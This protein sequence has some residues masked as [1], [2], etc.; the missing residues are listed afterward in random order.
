MLSTKVLKIVILRILLL[1]AIIFTTAIVGVAKTAVPAG[2]VP[3]YELTIRLL[4]E[5]H[6]IEVNGT[7]QLPVTNV[8][9]EFIPLLLNDTMHDFKVEVMSPAES[10]GS[11][12]VINKGGSSWGQVWLVI[13]NKPIPANQ[14]ALLKFSYNG[15]EKE[16]SIFYL[17]TEGSFAHGA[18]VAW[19][20]LADGNGYLGHKGKINFIVPDAY[21][22]VASGNLIDNSSNNGSNRFEFEVTEPVLFSF[23]CAKY[24]L[25]KRTDRVT[26][27]AYLLRP[28]ANINRYLDQCAQVLALFEKSFG[29]YPHKQF[30][31]VEIPKEHVKGFLMASTA[32]FI[33]TPG[34]FLDNEFDYAN[35]GHEMGHQW[36]GNLVGIKGKQ[37]NALL[38]EGMAQFSGLL[39]VEKFAGAKSLEKFRKDSLPPAVGAY[40]IDTSLG[41]SA[42][43]LGGRGYFLMAASGLDQR[44]DA[45]T[46]PMAHP[47]SVSKGALVLDLLSHTIGR[48]KF[49][50]MLNELTSRYAFKEIS[51]QNFL[52]IINKNNAISW[53]IDQWFQR[54]GAPLLKIDWQQQQGRL[55]GILSQSAPYYRLNLELEI[56]GKNGEKLI[57]EIEI[58]SEKKSLDLPV[59]FSVS[60]VVI[61]AHAQIPHWT[62]ALLLE[63]NLIKIFA[64]EQ[65]DI[66]TIEKEIKEVLANI[67][68]ADLNGKQ[69]ITEYALAY[70][71]QSQG[72]FK[73]AKDHL[74]TALQSAARI[75]QILPWAYYYLAVINRELGDIEAARD[76]INGAALAN[77]AI[78][79]DHLIEKKITTFAGTLVTD[80]KK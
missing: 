28:R 48:E 33:F 74:I 43:V 80:P 53:F 35:F 59:D 39:A 7:V 78:G 24:N 8:A 12:K 17:G 10:A 4:P 26:I 71:L 42:S 63:A 41:Y 5:D 54:E 2:V 66:S 37:G 18:N 69:F 56:Q 57:K 3:E 68:L 61:D 6:H 60:N 46:G 44:L 79:N 34:D 51:W 31:I 73:P 67:R 38:S 45:L 75:P 27:V 29:A 9:Q 16:A 11:A 32:G 62:L 72:Q 13:P 20:P 77:S 22:I 50:T 52:D 64:D 76:A 58:D 19:Y 55:I 36:W 47:L 23:G 65:K 40:T 25:V 15:G 70:R 49:F 1:S 14:N 21:Q 30:S